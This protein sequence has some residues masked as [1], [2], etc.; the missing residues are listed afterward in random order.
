MK[1][2]HASLFGMNMSTIHWGRGGAVKSA[3]YLINRVASRVINFETL[4]QKLHSLFFS[5]SSTKLRAKGVWLHNIYTHS[6]SSTRKIGSV[7]KTVCVCWLLEFQKGY[8]CYDPQNKR[9]YVTLNTSLCDS[10]PYYKG[11]VTPSSLRVGE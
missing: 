4:Q 8:R 7:C 10:K 9:L 1:I 2:V 5:S 3:T 11:G 6:Q